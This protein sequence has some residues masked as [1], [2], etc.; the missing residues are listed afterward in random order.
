MSN[1]ASTRAAIAKDPKLQ[2]ELQLNLLRAPGERRRR[3]Q[4]KDIFREQSLDLQRIFGNYD[5]IATIETDANTIGGTPSG[6]P[7]E[8][9]TSSSAPAVEATPNATSTGNVDHPNLVNVD[10][11]AVI[12]PPASPEGPKEV[13]TLINLAQHLAQNLPAK[14]GE[15]DEIKKLLKDLTETVSGQ[16]GCKPTRFVVLL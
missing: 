4:H 15:S 11:A 1:R 5:H 13:P 7:A 8:Q 14:M 12:T 6:E 16:D 10:H 9:L 3:R 2:R